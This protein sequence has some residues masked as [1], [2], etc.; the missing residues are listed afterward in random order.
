MG[1]PLNFSVSTVRGDP[2]YILWLPLSLL[3]PGSMWTARAWFGLELCLR[4]MVSSVASLGRVLPHTALGW[5]MQRAFMPWGAVPLDLHEVKEWTSAACM[6][7]HDDRSHIQFICHL[8]TPSLSP[9]SHQDAL[10]VLPP[11]SLFI[12]SVQISGG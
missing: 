10:N 12:L 1:G 4:G 8:A 5:A 6:Y 3:M 11:T 9:L 7:S 2:Q